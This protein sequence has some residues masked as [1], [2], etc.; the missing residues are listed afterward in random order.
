MGLG[1]ERTDGMHAGESMGVGGMSGVSFALPECELLF[2]M[3][4]V[5]VHT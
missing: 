1:M 4:F 3:I 5:A 2:L